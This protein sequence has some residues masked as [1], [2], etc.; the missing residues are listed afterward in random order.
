MSRYNPKFFDATYYLQQNADVAANWVGSVQEHFFQHGAAEGRKPAAWFDA[1]FLRAKY[2]DLAHMTAEQLFSHYNQF[3]FAEGRITDARFENFDAARYLSENA[4]LGAAGITAASALMHYM[5]FGSGEGRAAFATD[6]KAITTVNEIVTPTPVG[7]TFTLT[8]GADS[9]SPNS[10]VAANRTTEGNDL[11]RAVTNNSLETLDSIDGGAGID[12]LRANFDTSAGA[13]TTRPL[14]NSV[15]LIFLNANANTNAFTFNAAD[16]TGAQQIWSEGSVIAAGGTIAIN[17]VKLGTTVGVKDSAAAVTF[18]FAGATGNADAATLALADSTANVTIDA[19]ENVTVNSTT[20]SIAATTVN[21]GTLTFAAA[22]K[23]VVTGDQALTTTITAGNVKEIDASAFSKALT[24]THTTGPSAVTIKGG[25]GADTFNITDDTNDKV[26]IDMGA[27]NDTLN[28]RTNA[29]HNI[30]T[31]AG[32]DTINITFAAA[33]HKSIDISSAAKLAESAIVITDFTS[34]A[35]VLNIAAAVGG[36]KIVLT[37][38]QLSTVAGSS[39]LLTATQAAFTAAAATK[40]GAL[41]AGDGFSFQFGGNTYVV[42]D[43]NTTANSLSTDDL[44][45]QLTGV[46]SVVAA[47]LAIS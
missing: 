21:T 35:D 33:T 17:N 46:T 11:I 16:T 23:V 43:G 12:T 4:D 31:G 6:G 45:I 32:N 22:E 44:I 30:T 2:A 39:N 27:G 13:V 26:T 40:G 29:F 42:V 18:A 1:Q 37:G 24:L 41:V 3:G 38:T 20:G 28:I 19:I 47:D 9:L 5:A 14:L 10:A 34:G 25:V 8:V 36:A 15:E 7:Q